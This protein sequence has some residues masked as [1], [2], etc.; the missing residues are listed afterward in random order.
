MHAEYWEQI[1]L[2]I[3]QTVDRRHVVQFMLKLRSN[4]KERINKASRYHCKDIF[5]ISEAIN[6]HISFICICSIESCMYTNKIPYISD[7]FTII[8]IT[9]L[10]HTHTHTRTHAHTH[11]RTH[12]IVQLKLIN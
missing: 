3:R 2:S 7:I 6:I 11:A 4:R 9:A 8:L 5:I 1:R 10:K 12:T